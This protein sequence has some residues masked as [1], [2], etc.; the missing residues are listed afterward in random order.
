MLCQHRDIP[1]IVWDT[2]T[3][4][5]CSR[6][7]SLLCQLFLAPLRHVKDQTQDNNERQTFK[8]MN[9]RKQICPFLYKFLKT[10]ILYILLNLNLKGPI[11]PMKS[12]LAMSK[13]TICPK[14]ELAAMFKAHSF[15]FNFN[16]HSLSSH[17]F[18]VLPVSLL[19]NS[20]PPK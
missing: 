9:L 2:K 16:S 18:F 5:N 13:I 15:L 1:S 6:G 8:K 10:E 14:T 4:T 12:L 20:P 3:R 7:S 17:P 19:T 11:Q